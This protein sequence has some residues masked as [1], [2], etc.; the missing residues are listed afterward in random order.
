MEFK[1]GC[2]WKCNCTLY[3]ITKEIYGH[4]DDAGV[5]SPVSLI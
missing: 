4:V 3:E 1:E 5:G 2:G